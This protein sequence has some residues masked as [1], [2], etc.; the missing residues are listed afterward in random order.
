MAIGANWK[1]VW[2]P[3]WKA[4]W[5][6]EAATGEIPEGGVP[7]ATF[8]ELDGVAMQNKQIVQM[9]AAILASGVLECH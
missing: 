8:G 5:T 1:E 9:V 4:V 3:V 6:T 7:G 2:K